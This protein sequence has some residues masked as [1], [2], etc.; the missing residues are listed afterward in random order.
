M[1]S[2]AD[3]DEKMAADEAGQIPLYRFWQPRYWGLW[4]VLLSLRAITAL[5]F[6]WQLRIGQALGRMA[7]PLVPKRRN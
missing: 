4:L 5:P 6:R 1:N 2:R 7:M 3:S